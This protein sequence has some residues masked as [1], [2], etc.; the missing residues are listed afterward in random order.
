MIKY[1]SI[2]KDS[3]NSPNDFQVLFRSIEHNNN[4]R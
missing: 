1:I 3:A 2:G 4:T